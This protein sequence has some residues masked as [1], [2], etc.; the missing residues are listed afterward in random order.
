[1]ALVGISAV[2]SLVIGLVLYYFAGNRLVAIERDLLVQRSETANAG[3]ED[4]LEGLRSPEDRTLPPPDTYAEELV[5]QVAQSTGLGVLYIGPNGKPLAARSEPL[6]EQNGLGESRPPEEAYERLNL[7]EGIVDRALRSPDGGRLV[8]RRGALRY[9]AVRP[10]TGSGGNPQGVMV[11]NSPQDKL[12]Q[13]LT[14]LRYR[15]LGAIGASILLAAAGSLLISREITRPL[16]KTPGRRYK[17]RLGR[18]RPRC[19]WSA[20]TNWAK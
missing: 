20:K 1:M 17:S 9:I 15:I 12:D 4:I 3:A 7:T 19:R 13:T 8:P 14:S 6:D 18:L 5:Q 11:Y 2:T 16:S 10:L